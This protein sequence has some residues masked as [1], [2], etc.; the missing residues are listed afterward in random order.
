MKNKK[1]LFSFLGL[2]LLLIVFIGWIF[3]CFSWETEEDV[4]F[5]I[6]KGDKVFGIGEKL[7]EEGIIKNSFVFSSYAFISKKS[8]G[9]QAGTYY[10][11]SGMNIVDIVDLFHNGEVSFETITVIEG[12]S[13]QEVGSYFQE[14]GLSSGKD[15][16]RITGVSEEQATLMGTEGE[17]NEPLFSDLDILKHKPK[18]DSLE[19]YL[20]P[21][22]YRI[23]DDDTAEDVVLMMIKNLERKI[24][25]DISEKITLFGKNIHEV[26]IMASLLEKEVITMEDKRKVADILWRRIEVGMPLQIDAT[27]N[28]VTGRKGIDVTIK[29]TEV[30]SLYNTYKYKGLPRGPICNP[31]IE[32]IEAV[33]TPIKNEYWYYLSDPATGET[34]FSRNHNEH[35]Q[36]K[37][38]YLK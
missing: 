25:G 35:I 20:F 16:F 26:I 7:E 12:W 11:S 31:G 6:E 23:S 19:G 5:K 36:A 18:G 14:K 38:R 28:Y 4:F 8:K 27:V 33:V 2:F 34:I 29:E 10:I 30:D 9:L 37:N 15:F 21:D 24:D 1:T 32:S 17:A 13:L 3:S 22:T